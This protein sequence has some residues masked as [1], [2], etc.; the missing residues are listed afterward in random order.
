MHLTRKEGSVIRLIV[1]PRRHKGEQFLFFQM[2]DKSFEIYKCPYRSTVYVTFITYGAHQFNQQ[3]CIFFTSPFLRL[4]VD[5]INTVHSRM[6]LFSPNKQGH[7]GVTLKGDKTRGM[8]QSH[9]AGDEKHH[10]KT[11][12]KKVRRHV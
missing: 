8:Q 12:K 5:L 10:E 9:V 3:L 7:V 2:F 11:Q 6:S 4:A 1:L